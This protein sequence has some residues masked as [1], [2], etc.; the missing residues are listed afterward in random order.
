MRKTARCPPESTGFRTAGNETT[1]SAASMSASERRLAYG[2][3]GSSLAPS[4]SRIARLCVRRCAVF[5]PIPGR[6]SSSATAA[7]TGTARS[8]DTVSTPSTPTR[9]ATSITSAT[10]VKSTT[11]GDVGRRKA[12]RV[13]VAV[14]RGH[15]QAAGA[16]LLDGTALVASRRRRREPLSRPPMLTA[17]RVAY[18]TPPGGRSHGDTRAQR[19]ISQPFVR[20]SVV[21]TRFPATVPTIR[22]RCGPP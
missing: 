4:V 9:R 17:A 3:C 1:A 15:A 6:P 7:T 2:G 21:H 5:V 20:V 14:D 22:A 19:L 13:R 16:R 11:S 10:V 8:A 12:R 18:V